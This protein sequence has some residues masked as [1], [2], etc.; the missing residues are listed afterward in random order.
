MPEEPVQ[1]I[2]GVDTH[3]DTHT[4]VAIDQI[5]QRLDAIEIPATIAG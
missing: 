2:V 1:V 5:G 3:T 4:A